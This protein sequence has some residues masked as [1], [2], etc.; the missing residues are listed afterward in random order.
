[1]TDPRPVP[2]QAL[3]VGGGL[4]V[5]SG[6]VLAASRPGGWSVALIG[7]LA[8]LGALIR[9]ARQGAAP[10]SLRIEEQRSL[11]RDSGVAL[12]W[13]EGQPVLIAYG[14]TGLQIL[15]LEPRVPAEVS[16]GC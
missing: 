5:A 11:G 1:M 4:L 12:L 3:M 6:L 2:V 7:V 14:P 16:R 9:P 15:R 13:A 8:V 10:P